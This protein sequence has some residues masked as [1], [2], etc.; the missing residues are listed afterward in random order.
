[1]SAATSIGSSG[2][3]PLPLEAEL[4]GDVDHRVEVALHRPR[5]EAG[6][7][8]VVRGLPQRVVGVRGEQPR[9]LVGLA[10]LPLAEP[11]ELVEAGVVAEVVDHLQAVGDVDRPGGGGQLEDGSPLAPELHEVLDHRGLLDLEHVAQHRHALGAG[12]VV[13]GLR[14]GGSGAV[15]T[16]RSSEGRTGGVGSAVGERSGGGGVAQ[17]EHGDQHDPRREDEE[18]DGVVGHGEQ[19]E[20]GE[21]VG[22]HGRD[23]G[24]HLGGAQ[25]GGGGEGEHARPAHREDEHQPVA[26][27]GERPRHR[28]VLGG[29]VAEVD[30]RTRPRRPRRCPRTA[31]SRR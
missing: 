1:M 21:Q 8:D 19:Q 29:C 23:R 9:A 14:R 26:E 30:R 25:Q 17:Q 22:D 10:E 4:L 15:M 24:Q 28:R 16:G 20:R 12:D 7:Q 31:G 11:D 5:A 27:P 2:L 6:Q 13:Q 3:Q 18:G